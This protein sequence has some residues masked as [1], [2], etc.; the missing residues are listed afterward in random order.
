MKGLFGRISN[1]LPL[2]RLLL[3]VNFKVKMDWVSGQ[4]VILLSNFK[5]FRCLLMAVVSRQKNISFLL[6]VLR[7]NSFPL[8]KER[9][10]GQH[11]QILESLIYFFSSKKL[12]SLDA[13]EVEGFVWKN[14]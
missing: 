10:H 6:L 14:L 3:K 11:Q 8:N 9:I 13:V 12:F 7:N 5:L 1:V 4:N 2:Y